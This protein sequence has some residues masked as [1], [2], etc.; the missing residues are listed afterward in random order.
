MSKTAM[1]FSSP[2]CVCEA[3]GPLCCT[4][5][6]F[7]GYIVLYTY[8]TTTSHS[9][10]SHWSCAVVH[11]GRMNP[12]QPGSLLPVHAFMNS[13]SQRRNPWDWQNCHVLR[14][15]TS[16]VGLNS[17]DG[18]QDT[19]Q[20]TAVACVS[21]HLDFLLRRAV[22]CNGYALT[23]AQPELRNDREIVMAAIERNGW[24]ACHRMLALFQRK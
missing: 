12:Q 16:R 8:S 13:H 22:R 3:I 17:H 7:Q 14:P 6:A 5:A 15:K 19:I 4:V 24:S 11:L 23:Y 18:S 10:G 9:I 2:M 1:P 20:L 21:A